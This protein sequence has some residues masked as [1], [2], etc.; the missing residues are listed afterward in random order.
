MKIRRWRKVGDKVWKTR[1]RKCW[2]ALSGNTSGLRRGWRRLT[3]DVSHMVYS[4]RYPKVKFNH[5]HKQA[6]LE[7]EIIKF[8]ISKGWLN[9]TLKP[10]VKVL[11]RND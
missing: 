9:G 10:K 7:L 4:Y 5:S 2:I 8:V 6:E 11:S 1:V 3:H